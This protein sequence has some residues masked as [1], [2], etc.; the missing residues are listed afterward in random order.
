MF[1]KMKI[2]KISDQGFIFFVI[3]ALISYSKS[4][5]LG[6]VDNLSGYIKLKKTN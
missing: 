1:K 5:I 4:I 3:S 2:Q 6:K